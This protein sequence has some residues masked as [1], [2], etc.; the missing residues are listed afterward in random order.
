MSIKNITDK[1]LSDAKEKAAEILS[2][3]S[4][5]AEILVS[6]KISEASSQEAHLIS[7]AEEEAEARKNRIIQNAE[8]TVRNEKLAAKHQVI[9]KAFNYA[10]DSLEKLDDS[11]FI[12]FVK[13]TL[14]SNKISGDGF[15]K[16]NEARYKSVTPEVLRDIN[17][18][19]G[20][21][22]VLGR[23]IDKDGFMVDQRGIQI[24]CTFEALVESLKEDLIF[25]VT[26]I[27]FE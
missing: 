23:A 3:S 20:T 7:K 26:K 5:E 11:D 16:V 24:N 6:S 25:D 12:N 21:N 9:E 14:K 10:L 18:F 27:L 1:I 15:L 17:T 2:N 19:S 13:S 4:K 22:L 8:L